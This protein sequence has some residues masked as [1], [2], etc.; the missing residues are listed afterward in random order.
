MRSSTS[1]TPSDSTTKI[2]RTCGSCRTTTAP[3]WPTAFGDTSLFERGIRQ[4][5]QSQKSDGALHSHPPSDAPHY[6][7]D[8]SLTWID[9]VWDFYEYTG[10][11]DMPAECMATVHR[12]LELFARH[13]IFE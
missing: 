7:P 13:E 8:F 4:V 2:S 11:T 1:S 6:L 10:R 5:R 9:S 12:V 3:P